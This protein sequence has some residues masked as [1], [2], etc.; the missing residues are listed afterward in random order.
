MDNL[1]HSL[2]GLAAAKAG[3]ERLSPGATT[4]CVLAA[5][6]P[7]A[8]IVALIF[9]GRWVFLQHHRGISH[10]IAGALAL[11]LALP[12]IFCLGGLLLAGWRKRRQIVG[13]A[14]PGL[15][16]NEILL[17]LLWIVALILLV[18]LYRRD[19]GGRAGAKI[20]IAALA[21]VTIY[22]SG[23]AVTHVV[24][25]RRA[26][27]QA[28]TI[29]SQNTE[30]VIKIAAMPTVANPTEWTCVMET[31]RATYRF[32]LSLLQ[33][34]PG[35]LNVVRYEKPQ[36]LVA[37]AVAEAAHDNRSQVF[38][39]FARFPVVQVVGEDCLTQ[40]LVHFADLRY[41]E[42]GRSRGTF[43]LDVP[44]ECPT[45]ETLNR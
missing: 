39:G 13:P 17:R 32:N 31:D 40:T 3:L 4:L 10:S 8:D 30:R 25:L 20:A 5:N 24:A 34:A 26:K 6:S 29:A 19:I 33:T 21:T 44:V 11:A 23:L 27:L 36:G 16:T 15:M 43:S 9:G 18:S 14:G 41:T 1:T 22:C 45:L 28:V 2:I 35:D 37:E 12:P 38:L 42:P 7:D